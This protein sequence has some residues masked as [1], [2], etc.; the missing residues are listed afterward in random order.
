MNELSGTVGFCVAEAPEGK[1]KM[2]LSCSKAL[3]KRHG[4]I[5]EIPGNSFQPCSSGS[6]MDLNFKT[7]LIHHW[8][9]TYKESKMS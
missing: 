9:R 1:R 7:A 3:E 4:K 2:K 6:T 5:F 8:G